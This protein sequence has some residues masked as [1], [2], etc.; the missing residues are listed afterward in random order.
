M[1]I[2]A[3]HKYC[4]AC[5]TTIRRENVIK[6]SKLGRLKTTSL[7]LGEQNHNGDNRQ[8]GKAGARNACRIGWMRKSIASKFNLNFPE[9]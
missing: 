2:K 9:F 8:L 7:R 6:A 3:A 4:R 5:A 1:K